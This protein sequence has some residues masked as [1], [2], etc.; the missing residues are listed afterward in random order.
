M[1]NKKQK[2]YYEFLFKNNVP[3]IY[4]SVENEIKDKEKIMQQ[5]R[6]SCAVGGLTK[7]EV[8]AI[9]TYCESVLQDNAKK[10]ERYLE[11]KTKQSQKTKYK[12]NK[13]KSVY[14]RNKENAE[15]NV[16]KYYIKHKLG[17]VMRY[18]ANPYTA[19]NMF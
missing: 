10:I 11:Y 18:L 1:A 9:F 12:N 17:E 13:H 2:F 8:S 14:V 19:E 5:A 4:D 15:V 16:I 3:T 7:K 6:T